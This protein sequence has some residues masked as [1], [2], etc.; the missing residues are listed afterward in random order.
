[1]SDDAIRDSLRRVLG[2]DARPGLSDRLAEHRL[3]VARGEIEPPPPRVSLRVVATTVA[4]SAALAAGGVLML[5]H[6]TASRLTPPSGAASSAPAVA[7]STPTAIGGLP[8]VSPTGATTP[9]STP[10]PSAT[11]TKS[12]TPAPVPDC[13]GADLTGSLSTGGSATYTEGASVPIS[14]TITNHSSHPCQLPFWCTWGWRALDASGH[15]VAASPAAAACQVSG[16][17]DVLLPGASITSQQSHWYTQ[18]QPAPAGSY[19]ITA[20]LDSMAVASA[21]VTLIGPTTTQTTTTSS[22]SSSSTPIL[23]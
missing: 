19:T 13:Q 8:S 14:E 1:M 10:P 23:P 17:H 2:A 20:S 12:A 5:Q 4:L 21:H 16:S 18:Y 22:S 7:A 15:V 3:R 9:T 11:A 6:R